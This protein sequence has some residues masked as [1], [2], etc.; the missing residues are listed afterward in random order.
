MKSDAVLLHVPVGVWQKMIAYVTIC[1]TEI[2]GFGLVDVIGPNEFALSDVFI[3]DQVAA[4]AKVEWTELGLALC[5][6]DLINR[7]D[8]PRRLRFQWHSHVNMQAFFSDI[9]TG[10]IEKWSG[11]WLISLVVNKHGEYEVRLD[12]FKSLRIR[13]IPVTI[14][15]DNPID[16]DLIAQCQADIAQHVSQPKPHKIKVT[17]YVPGFTDFLDIATG[18][19]QYA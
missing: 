9:D 2:N 4:A 10:G 18:D 3:T 1:S 12:M 17:R 13:N 8:D 15:F 19:D 5:I 14:V 6:T 7:G 16:P 11:D